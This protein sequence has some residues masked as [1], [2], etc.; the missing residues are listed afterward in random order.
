VLR[1]PIES[2][3]PSGGS[4]FSGPAIRPELQSPQ[5]VAT[6]WLANQSY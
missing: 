3:T 4:I 2:K 1:L 5:S 6:G